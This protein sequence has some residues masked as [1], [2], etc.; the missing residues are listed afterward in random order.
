T[1]SSE[2]P[3]GW[4][5]LLLPCLAVLVAFGWAVYAHRH[6]LA[7]A[8]RDA[9]VA[10]KL[11]QR[12][13]NWRTAR[14]PRPPGI[15]FRDLLNLCVALPGK[16]I[17]RVAR[18]MRLRMKSPGRDIELF[19]LPTPGLEPLYY[20]ALLGD[21]LIRPIELAVIELNVRTFG[22]PAQR[23]AFGQLSQLTSKI[24]LA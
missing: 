8:G 14:F 11:P 9:V 7:E 2:R 13:D 22:D 6:E 12:L 10:G 3:R 17:H 21:V 5:S 20:Y 16:E 23:G 18:F 15:M 19:D 4:W 1:S 24:G